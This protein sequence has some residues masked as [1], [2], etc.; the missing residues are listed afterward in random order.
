[1]AFK[2]T[3]LI[4]AGSLAALF[5]L[6]IGFI[7][8]PPGRHLLSQML[9][10]HAGRE[11]TLSGHIYP[12]LSW[13]LTLHVSR[14]TVAN[15]EGGRNQDMARIGAMDISMAWWALFHREIHVRH[16]ALADSQLNLER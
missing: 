16:L 1:M 4:V 9:T 5:I 6:P 2:K 10:H 8:I 15:I 14:L 7:N 13:P 12:R 3:F 11:V